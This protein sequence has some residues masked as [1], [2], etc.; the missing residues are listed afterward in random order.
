[1]SSSVFLSSSS[2][3]LHSTLSPWHMIDA[4]D[5]L[6]ERAPCWMLQQ[7]AVDALQ[8]QIHQQYCFYCHYLVSLL[9]HRSLC[10]VSIFQGVTMELQ[11]RPCWQ[12]GKIL[13]GVRYCEDPTLLETKIV[14]K[15]WQVDMST[16]FR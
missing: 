5:I 13:C 12:G 1:L 3:V 15:C 6:L 8:Q 9:L 10:G 14:F 2:F 7:M 16:I 11:C 4:P